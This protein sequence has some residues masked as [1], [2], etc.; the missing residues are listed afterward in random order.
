MNF[1]EIIENTIRKVVREELARHKNDIVTAQPSKNDNS[2]YGDVGW[3]CKFLGVEKQTVYGY[4]SARKYPFT[5]KGKKVMYNK[6]EIKKLIESNRIQSADEIKK[7]AF[8]DFTK[9]RTKKAG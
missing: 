9:H 8:Q 7:H 4:N 5:K 3:L 2:K 6:E 1:E